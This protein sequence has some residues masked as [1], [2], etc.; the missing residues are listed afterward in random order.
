MENQFA[1]LFSVTGHNLGAF[2]GWTVIHAQPPLIRYAFFKRPVSKTM[3]IT[4][5]A[6]L[7]IINV[8]AMAAMGLGKQA[9]VVLVGIAVG[10]YY[11]L[12]VRQR[13][14]VEK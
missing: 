9:H 10:S 1:E 3:A 8:I 11:L 4:I 5:S 12:R 7:W 14:P 13:E 2:W 6:V